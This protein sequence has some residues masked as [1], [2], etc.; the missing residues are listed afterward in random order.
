MTPDRTH[1]RPVTPTETAG[2]PLLL[3]QKASEGFGVEPFGSHDERVTPSWA[4]LSHNDGRVVKDCSARKSP[5]RPSLRPIRAPR[6]PRRPLSFDAGSDRGALRSPKLFLPQPLAPDGTET[7]R[8]AEAC[9][10]RPSATPGRSPV[11]S[12]GSDNARL[13]LIALRSWLGLSLSPRCSQR[14]VM[15]PRTQQEAAAPGSH[16]SAFVPREPRPT[17]GLAG[18][19]NT[20]SQSRACQ[21]AV[22]VPLCAILGKSLALKCPL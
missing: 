21:A 13:R 17:V 10:H 2:D 20:T 16:C 4:Q 18:G 19:S 6:G 5:E 11:Q 14:L 12:R 9:W 3:A 7:A 22:C 15:V 8:V 1:V